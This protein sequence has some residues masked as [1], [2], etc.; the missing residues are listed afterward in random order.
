MCRD[1]CL[2]AASS[3]HQPRRTP[4]LL[5]PGRIGSTSTTSCAMTTRLPVARALSQLCHASR[6]HVTRL[7]RLYVNLAVHREYSSPGCSDSTSTTP[8]VRVPRQVTR[9]VLPLV[10][11]YFTYA[12]L[13]GATTHRAARCV[14]RRRLLLPHRASGYLGTSRDSSYGSSSTTPRRCASE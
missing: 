8:R 7:Q 11:D 4:R 5:A 9:L 14:A 6:L 13:T 3:L 2:P 12:S 1:T 10:L